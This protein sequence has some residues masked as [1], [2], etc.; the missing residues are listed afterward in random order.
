[1]QKM[2]QWAFS[3]MSH[4]AACLFQGLDAGAGM[5]AGTLVYIW[6]CN[7]QAQQKW[8][9]DSN[10]GSIYT[11]AHL[12]WMSHVPIAPPRVDKQ[13]GGPFRRSI[14]AESQHPAHEKY[15]MAPHVSARHHSKP[16]LFHSECTA[17]FILGIPRFGKCPPQT[18]KFPQIVGF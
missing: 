6:D 15:Q 9:Y 14:S 11:F 5:K 8:G 12:G 2:Y 1:M 4:W 10:K 3:L 13:L 17:H 18:F 16:F 7:G